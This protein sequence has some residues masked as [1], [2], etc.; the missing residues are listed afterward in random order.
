MLRLALIA[1]L[2]L[3][4]AEMQAAGKSG[5]FCSPTGNCVDSYGRNAGRERVSFDGP[6][7]EELVR[8]YASLQHACGCRG[9]VEQERIQCVKSVN[10]LVQGGKFLLNVSAVYKRSP[11]GLAENSSRA[12]AATMG[13]SISAPPAN[14]IK[15]RNALS[16]V[17]ISF[18]NDSLRLEKI[19]EGAQL[20]FERR[21]ASKK[22]TDQNS[23]NQRNCFS[24]LKN[25]FAGFRNFVTRECG[26]ACAAN[27]NPTCARK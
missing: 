17:G 25:E 20:P 7:S 19:S 16:C 8:R 18:R 26:A 1:A 27:A 5:V 22:N 13:A 10:Q 15:E 21:M 2:S 23:G 4:A 14:S 12:K 6:T 3:L 9:M 11:A 24:D